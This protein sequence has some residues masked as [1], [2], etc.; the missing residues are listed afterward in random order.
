MEDRTPFGLLFF[1][2]PWEATG[3][4]VK[5]KFVVPGVGVEPTRPEGQGIL[6]PPRMPF[7]HPGSDWQAYLIRG[8]AAI[9]GWRFSLEP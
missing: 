2:G 6:S 4:I 1:S 3:W 7:R 9:C 5:S 8:F